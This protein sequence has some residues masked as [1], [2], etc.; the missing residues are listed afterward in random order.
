MSHDWKKEPLPNYVETLDGEVFKPY[1]RDTGYCVSTFGRVVGPRG[2][3]VSTYYDNNGYQRVHTRN[4][5]VTSV[6]R[7]VAITFI[8]NPD[9]LPDVNHKDENKANNRVE[10]LEWVSTKYNMNYGTLRQ[11]IK[12]T[13][14]RNKDFANFCCSIAESHGFTKERFHAIGQH[15]STL[16]TIGARPVQQSL[17]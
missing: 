3:I 9:N 12:K 8:P 16:S 15:F 5:G 17:F 10:N 1:P 13:R 14:Q 2:W 11:R 6:H 4:E 7:M